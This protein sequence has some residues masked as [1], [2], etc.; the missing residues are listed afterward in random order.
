MS[1]SDQS[2]NYYWACLR[3]K[4][5]KFKVHF[6]TVNV[7]FKNKNDWKENNHLRLLHLEHF[8]KNHLC[9]IYWSSCGN[10]CQPK[11]KY[12]TFYKGYIL[13]LGCK[14]IYFCFIIDE[15]L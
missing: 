7:I 15:A 13:S 2:S 10:Q 9:Y 3:C 5:E 8:D 11:D 1:A 6:K 14:Y 12:C 4:D